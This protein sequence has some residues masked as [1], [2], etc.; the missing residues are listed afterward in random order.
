VIAES[1][2]NDARLVLPKMM[3]GCGLDAQWN[4]DFHHALHSLLTGESDG[5]YEDF[6]KT[7]HLEK[8][9]REGFVYSGQYSTFRKRKHG[10]FSADR[11]AHQFV[12]FSQNHDQVGNRMLG[13]RLSSLVSF[14]ALK[15]AAAVVLLSPN[16]PLLFMGEEYGED[17]P[18]LYFADHGDPSLIEAVRAGRKKEF[19]AFSWEGEPPDPQSEETFTASRLSWEKRGR[20]EHAVLLR[21]YRTLIDLRRKTP[22]LSELVRDR[23]GVAAVAGSRVVTLRRWSGTG[24]SH[25]YCLFNFE[26]NDVDVPVSAPNG[27]WKKVLDSSDR[28]WN[29]PGTD[30]PERVGEGDQ[31]TLR[32]QSAVLFLREKVS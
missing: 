4:D 10:N 30:L 24:T 18:F 27:A 14:E 13:E 25:A 21:F 22:A 11:L 29:G 2:L 9:L 28:I 16:V 5:Y 7:D 20:G 31:V 12:V 32:A 19:E 17:A 8:T 6:G 23:L 3:G 1:D 26:Q 15:L